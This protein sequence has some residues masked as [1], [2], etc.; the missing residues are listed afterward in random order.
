MPAS[1]LASPLQAVPDIARALFALEASF[2][3]SGLDRQ[4]MEL[5][6]QRASQLN[7]CVYCLHQHAVTARVFGELDMRLHMLAGW[8]ESSLYSPREKAALGWTEALTLVE[9]TH[10]PDSAYAALQAEFEPPEQVQLTFLIGAINLWNRL[11]VGFRVP[12]PSDQRDDID[13]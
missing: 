4:L 11:Q 12:H 8:R 3:A 9:R 5:V 7:G 2:E 10:A 13:D 6:R 1:R